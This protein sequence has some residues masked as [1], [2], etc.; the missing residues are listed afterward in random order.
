M[1]RLGLLVLL[2]SATAASAADD[3]FERVLPG[4][5]QDLLHDASS[6]YD[7]KDYARAFELNQ[8][9]AC[10][11]DKTSQAILGRMYILGQGVPRDDVA[12]YAWIRLAADFSFADFTSLARKLEAAMTPAQKAAG[13][14]KADVLRKNYG[15][16]ATNMSC[17]GES[18][19]GVY[20]IDSVVCT[21][22]SEGGRL[23]LRRCEAA[24]H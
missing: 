11:G 5:Y 14:A 15:P 18:R 1:K 8:R 10:A 13:E 17:H 22:E 12:G 3:S 6:A 20:L 4:A 21:P 24:A 2:L 7:K 9:G 23:L 16:A 19:R